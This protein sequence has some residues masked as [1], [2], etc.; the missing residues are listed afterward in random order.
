[1]GKT[2]NLFKK[3]GDI[4]G[5]FHA[6]M[7]IIKDRNSKDLKKQERLRRGSKNKQKNS[8]IKVLMTQ[9]TM[10]VCSLFLSWTSKSMKSRK[11]YYKQS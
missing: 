4:K 9:K 3:S 1:M 2:K 10:M 11:H 5:N 8:T 6:G 7:G